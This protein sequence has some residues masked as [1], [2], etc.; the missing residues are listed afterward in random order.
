MGPTPSS[1]VS[2]QE[3]GPHNIYR[4][5][6]LA[7]KPDPELGENAT[8]EGRGRSCIPA[9]AG[10]YLQITAAVLPRATAGTLCSQEGD[11]LVPACVPARG[12]VVPA[13]CSDSPGLGPAQALWLSKHSRWRR[14]GR[15]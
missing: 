3:P 8:Q 5:T 14:L 2:Q 6:P 15:L 1:T 9:G 13:S 12:R 10:S 11:T 4:K 7:L